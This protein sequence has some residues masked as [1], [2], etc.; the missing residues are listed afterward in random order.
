MNRPVILL[1]TGGQASVLYEILINR[2][3]PILGL[4]APHKPSRTLFAA[5][6]WLGDDNSVLQ[7]PIDQVL[8]V[9]AVGSV[10]RI[11]QRRELFKKFKSRGYSF[12]S[13]V[14]SSAIISALE[15]EVGEGLQVMA[16]AII[17]TCVRIEENVLI[18]TRAVVEHDCRIGRH[19]HVAS[20]AVL[21]GGCV[22]GEGVHIGAGAA[23]NQGITIGDGAVIASGAVVTKNVTSYTL[24]A[25]VPAKTKRHFGNDN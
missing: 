23:I 1:G 7:S 8:L 13:V 24:V 12:A 10:G 11:Q 5:I 6:P 25:G 4:A 14:H 3:A 16:G 21:C 22:V 9:N 19:T 18:N 20:G 2:Q 17:N 15:I